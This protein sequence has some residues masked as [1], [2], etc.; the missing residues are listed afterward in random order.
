MCQ[1]CKLIEEF[2]YSRRPF[3]FFLS[4]KVYSAPITRTNPT[5][6][7]VLIDQSGSMAEKVVFAGQSMPKSRAVAL[8]A[9]SF[10]DELLHRA[11]RE[12]GTRDYYDLAVLGYG[13][14]GVHNLL[15]S[16]NGGWDRP[17]R[18]AVKRPAAKSHLSQERVLPSGRTV[19]VATEHDDW[20]AER[21]EGA[22][23]MCG[24]L[25]EALRMVERWCGKHPRSYPPTV[26]NITDGEVSDGTPRRVL[27]LAGSIRGT[28][29]E[30]GNTLLIN[31]H[32][33]GSDGAEAVLFPTDEEQLPENRY[34]RLLWDASS[35]LPFRAGA[36][37]IGFNCD[38]A[39]LAAAMNIGS[40]NSVMV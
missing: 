22:T 30:D 37:G 20:I 12:E 8:V 29:T 33:V 9:G 25:T 11:R 3:L 28:G 16:D 32:L 40:V 26:I 1:I 13:G 6:F 7:I 10:I 31:I 21:A 19:V 2:F 39:S 34:A 14:R 24:A 38:F 36:R 18:L 17:S 15:T 35:E 23:P 4:K 5:A 27:E